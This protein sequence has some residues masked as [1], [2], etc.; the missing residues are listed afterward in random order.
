MFTNVSMTTQIAGQLLP[1]HHWEAWPGTY[2]DAL[3]YVRDAWNAVL[4]DLASALDDD[5]RDELVLLTRWLTNPDPALRGHPHNRAGNGP[6]Y[7]IRRF[8]SRLHVL[9]TIAE[10]RIPFRTA[11]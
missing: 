4:D 3:H 8:S 11:A 6:R 1:Q 2:T 9:A 10:R 7:G 5:V